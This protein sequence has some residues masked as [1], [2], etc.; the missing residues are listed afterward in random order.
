MRFDNVALT[1]FMGCGKSTVG[2]LLA[3]QLEWTFIDV[4]C[5]IEV[6]YARPASKLFHE[7]G[8]TEFRLIEAE[9]TAHNLA[10]PQA[11]IALGGAAVDLP[12][13][14]QL[15]RER[16]TGLLVFLDGEFGV[17]VERCIRE[18][19]NKGATYRP[20]LHQPKKAL[21]RFSFRRD[22]NLANAGLRIDVSSQSCG[23]TANDITRFMESYVL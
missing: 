8:E 9:I 3:Q 22:W 15:L 1:G 11:V 12:V 14:Q 2:R 16:Y 7:L 18:A 4:D 5:Q 23:K 17:L 10:L 13:T 21:D 20:L 19:E 6:E